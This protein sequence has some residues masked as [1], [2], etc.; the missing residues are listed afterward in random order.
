MSKTYKK[1]GEIISRSKLKLDKIQ[2]GSSCSGKPHCI[3]KSTGCF[4]Y[5]DEKIPDGTWL[6]DGTFVGHV[7]GG[8]HWGCTGGNPGAMECVNSGVYCPGTSNTGYTLMTGC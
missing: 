2:G 7:C 3:I 8:N 5:C 1:L 6:C 4:K